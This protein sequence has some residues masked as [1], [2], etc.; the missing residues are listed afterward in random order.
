MWK[1]IK[2]YLALAA[3]QLFVFFLMLVFV[4]TDQEVLL[5]GKILGFIVK[6]VSGF[7][8]VIINDQLPYFFDTSSEKAPSSYFLLILLNILLQTILVFLGIRRWKKWKKN[9]VKTT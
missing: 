5:P 7:P 1:F 9:R 4:M 8:M 2:I 3:A 6:Y